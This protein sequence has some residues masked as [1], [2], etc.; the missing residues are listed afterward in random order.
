MQIS[1]L[2]H[3]IFFCLVLCGNFQVQTQVAEAA[4]FAVDTDPAVS[5]LTRPLILWSAFTCEILLLS[6]LSTPSP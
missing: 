3:S 4:S 5:S 2:F 1:A 6:P